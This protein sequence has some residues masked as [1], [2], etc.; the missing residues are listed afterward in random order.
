MGNFFT[1]LIGVSV[2][3]ILI[4][5]IR[6]IISILKD[7]KYYHPEITEPWSEY[8]YSPE[9]GEYVSEKVHRRFKKHKITGLWYIYHERKFIDGN[10]VLRDKGWCLLD[11]KHKEKAF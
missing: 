5:Y 6:L 10:G 7:R 4:H 2:F 8:L 3:F 9:I 11:P 1:C